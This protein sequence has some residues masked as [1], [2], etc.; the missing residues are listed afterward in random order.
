M[1]IETPVDNIQNEDASG[2]SPQTG[3]NS[4]GFLWIEL[5]VLSGAGIIMTILFGKKKVNN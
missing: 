5:Q 4:N 3:D 1:A 2:D